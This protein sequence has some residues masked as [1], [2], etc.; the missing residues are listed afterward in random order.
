VVAGNLLIVERLLAHIE[1]AATMSGGAVPPTR[2]NPA[3]VV[4]N[5]LLPWGAK[6]LSKNDKWEA[7]VEI[8]RQLECY[9]ARRDGV[10]FFD[11]TSL[12]LSDSG[13][14]GDYHGKDAPPRTEGNMMDAAAPP[15]Q[16]KNGAE[17]FANLTL[18]DR[19]HFHP[20]AEGYRVWGK[21]MV[22]WL[23]FL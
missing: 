6:S 12:F 22:E 13:S 17:M 7:A 18:F 8:N 11:A 10:H 5:S 19:D 2:R 1:A 15:P 23:E 21:A 14:G 9:A 20:G 3:R 4:I 16:P